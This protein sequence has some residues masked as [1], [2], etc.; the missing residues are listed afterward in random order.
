MSAAC[1][2]PC[3]NLGQYLPQAIQSA[4][5][6]TR[7]FAEI[8]VVDDGS[9]DD[10]FEITQQAGVGYLGLVNHG[11]CGARNAGVMATRSD[12]LVFLDADDFLEPRYLER[13]LPEFND[14]DVGVV[15]PELIT[16][17][18]DHWPAPTNDEIDPL[19]DVNYVWAASAVRRQAVV[20]AGG[21]NQRFSQAADWALWVDI[22]RRGGW[23]IKGVH[24]P[25][26]VWRDREDGMHHGINMPQM[27][28]Q[29]RETYA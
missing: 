25:L 9:T 1:I 26:W 29:L 3:Y 22:R 18:G 5:Q 16:T 11:Y 12:I 10:T 13:V 2:I 23:R 6:Q 20:Q 17:S 21:F 4:I 8:L 15:C 7:I 14:L 27:R 28:Q 19:F 24:E